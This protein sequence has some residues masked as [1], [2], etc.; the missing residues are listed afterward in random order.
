MLRKALT[1]LCTDSNHGIALPSLRSSWS[2]VGTGAWLSEVVGPS[3]AETTAV[4]RQESVCGSGERYGQISIVSHDQQG[5]V[6]PQ[7]PRG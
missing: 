2:A 7:R 4:G 6:T 1:W 3:S 5:A